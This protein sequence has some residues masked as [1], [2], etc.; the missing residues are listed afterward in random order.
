[1]KRLKSVKHWLIAACILTTFV[2]QLGFPASVL[3]VKQGG[4]LKIGLPFNPQKPGD[5][6][7]SMANGD[8]SIGGHIFNQL[9]DWEY[10]ENAKVTRVNPSLATKWKKSANGKIWTF[11][12][13]KGVKF[14]DGSPFNAEAVKVNLDRL[15]IGKPKL[16]YGRDLRPILDRTEVVNSH[17]VKLYL[18][19]LSPL[20]LAFLGQ[21]AAGMVSPTAL[22]K[23]PGKIARHPIG[24]G[25]F[26]V[27][28]WISGQSIELAANKNYWAGRPNLDGILFR[29]VPDSSAR[30]NMM[31]V[32]ELDV[33][34]SV[35]VQDHPRI[36]KSKNFEVIVYPTA[37]I[38][39]F[40]LDCGVGPTSE[41]LVRQ[42]MN[43]A[44]DKKTMVNEILQGVGQTADSVVA[45]F[46][47]G[48]YG[49]SKATYNPEKAKQLLKKA[50]WVDKDGDGIREKNGKKLT[51]SLMTTPPDR[52]LMGGEI[53]LALQEYMRAVGFDFKIQF[54]EFGAWIGK[55]YRTFDTTEGNVF[56][57]DYSSRTDAM[58]ILNTMQSGRWYPNKKSTIFWKNDEY[59]RLYKLAAVEVDDN[60]RLQQYKRMQEI[61]ADEQPMI[62]LYILSQTVAKKKNVHGLS[63]VPIPTHKVFMH[64]SKAWID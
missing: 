9:V 42:A 12:L 10:D 7:S 59:D 47:W 2:I 33:I 28:K 11:Y 45:P 26:K 19:V 63:L 1:M 56:F 55:L 14:H 36:N 62:D 61:L 53:V 41:I 24:T 50:G 25:P 18:K 57:F 20:L 58:F 3:A 5:P 34:W 29:V 27:K 49:A 51:L 35:P 21:Y 39:R 48:Y 46:T 43:Y 40:Y 37:G 54:M 38:M 15:T 8:Q 16:T 31:S 52:Y 30:I 6:G 60:K 64:A 32:G 13:R 4:I 23:Y 17:T 44:I 22:K